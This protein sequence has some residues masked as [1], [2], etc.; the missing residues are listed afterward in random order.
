[1]YRLLSKLLYRSQADQTFKS[2]VQ[3]TVE[4]NLRNWTL[5]AQEVYKFIWDKFILKRA[6]LGKFLKNY[7]ICAMIGYL[8]AENHYARLEQYINKNTCLI[9]QLY[10][11]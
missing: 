5:I 10:L 1:M 11:E 3:I 6:E 7:R 9:A 8:L 4:K 2:I